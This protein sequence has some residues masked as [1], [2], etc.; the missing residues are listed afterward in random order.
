VAGIKMLRL[1]SRH[2]AHR[3]KESPRVA[4]IK[5]LRLRSRHQAHRSKERAQK[6]PRDQRSYS[7]AQDKQPGG[8]LSVE[9]EN[10]RVQ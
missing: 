8:H 9:S 7:R 10:G 5:M 3:S 6:Q 4:G 2:Q 1:R